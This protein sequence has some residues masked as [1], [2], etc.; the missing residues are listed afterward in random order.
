MENWLQLRKITILEELTEDQIQAI[1][2]KFGERTYKKRNQLMHE[3]ERQDGIYFILKGKVKLTKMNPDGQEKVVAVVSEGEIIG[4]IVAFDGGACPYTAETM[5]EVRA[6]FLTIKDFKE[7]L[8]NY[9]P[10]AM[11]C[12]QQS[13]LRLRK[14]YRHMKN[15]ALLDTYGRMAAHL[16]KMTRDYG[17]Q[18]K[19]G[20][21]IN[22]NV[23]R[24]EMAQ[25][26]GTSRE[27][28][29]RVLAEFERMGILQV[30]RHQI[31]VLDIEELRERASGGR[32]NS[33]SN[34]W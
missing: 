25:F 9:S 17:V 12:L 20:I 22:F 13:A 3:G 10:V 27:T 5:E 21:R 19:E 14:A 34:E 11:A 18:E 15:L 32:K 26:I 6:A 23:T 28:V 31:T 2:P 29:S 30:D 24:Q 4:E 33:S 1:A 7:M 16:F 8:N